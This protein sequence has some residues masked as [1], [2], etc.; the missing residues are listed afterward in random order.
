MGENPKVQATP[1][2][3]KVTEYEKFID[4]VSD[5]TLHLTFKK[6]PSGVL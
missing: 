3:L 4:S 6:L 1:M 5:F 2:D